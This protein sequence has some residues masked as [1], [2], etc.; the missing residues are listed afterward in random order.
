MKFPNHSIDVVMDSDTFNE[1]DDQYALAYMLKSPEKLTVKAIY[2]A[3]FF[4]DHSTSAEDG[5]LQSYNEILKVLGLL[6]MKH[7]ENSVYRGSPS[8]LP[9]EKTPVDSAAVQN[10]IH[11]SHAYDC[12]NPLYVIAIGAITNIAS[13]LLIAPSIRENIVVVWLGGHSFDWPDT[14]EFNLRQDVAAARVVFDSGVP[15]IQL[16]CMGVVSELR[17][18]GPE[19]DYWLKGKNSFC[20]Y[21]IDITAREARLHTQ[22]KTWSRVIWDVAAVAWLLDEAY[23]ATRLES[24]PICQYDNH[25]SFD[26]C[27]HMIRYAYW[28]DRD[29]IFADLFAKLGQ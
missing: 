10:L 27:R 23:V 16:P 11:L 18:T 3:P 15:I 20:D 8:F 5:M 6:D 24:S 1:I 13:A 9:D 28:V 25:Y 19:L 22:E 17:T 12:D 21:L 26:R 2:A 29:R 7:Y 14:N 4:N